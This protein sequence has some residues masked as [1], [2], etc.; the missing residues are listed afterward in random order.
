MTTI[1]GTLANYNNGGPVGIAPGQGMFATDSTRQ[2]LFDARSSFVRMLNIVFARNSITIDRPAAVAA[3]DV[4]TPISEYL[5]WRRPTGTQHVEAIPPTTLWD[6]EVYNIDERN[7][8]LLDATI[9]QSVVDGDIVRVLVNG[10]GN[11]DAPQWSVYDAVCPIGVTDPAV[12]PTIPGQVFSVSKAYDFHVPTFAARDLLLQQATPI[13]LGQQVLVDGNTSTA[14]FWTVWRYVG[15]S[16]PNADASG[17]LLVNYQ[18]YRTADFWSHVDW[19]ATGYSAAEPPVVRYATIAARDAAEL[20]NPTTTFVRVDDDGTGVWVWTT[21]AD[22]VWTVVARQNGTIAFSS[23]FY[24]DPTRPVIGLGPVSD[25]VLAQIPNRD[26]SLELKV[27]FDILQDD[28]LLENSEINEIFFSILHFIHAQQ[29]QVA[30]AFKTSFLT[31]GGYNEVL[32]QAPVQ[33]PDNTTNLLNYLQEVTP[34]RVKTRDFTQ[35]VTPLI[36]N[37][38][39]HATDFD[40]PLYYDQGVGRYRNLNPSN[41]TDL[42]II[43][44][45]APWSDWYG[46]YLNPEFRPPNY[47]ASSWNG[48]RHFNITM[49]FDRVDHM[50]IL[51]DEEFTFG[52]NNTFFMNDLNVDLTLSIVEVYVNGVRLDDNQFGVS[53]NS[54]ILYVTMTNGDIVRVVVRQSLTSG[55]AADRINRFYDPTDSEAAERNLRTLL[56]LNF[57]GNVMDGGML[58]NNTIVDY[59]IIGVAN[60][61][62]TDETINPDVFFHSLADPYMSENHPEELIPTFGGEGILILANDNGIVTQMSLSRPATDTL[63]P[64]QVGDFDAVPLDTISFDVGSAGEETADQYLSNADVISGLITLTK[65]APSTSPNLLGTYRTS[66]TDERGIYV[67]RHDAWEFTNVTTTA[68][69]LNA[70]LTANANTISI[71]LTSANSITLPVVE[72]YVANTSVANTITHPGVIWI[73][74]ERIEFFQYTAGANN[75]VVLGQIRRGT[76]NTQIGVEHRTV[77]SFTADG[78]SK[79]FFIAN[80]PG[81]QC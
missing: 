77:L 2:G 26:G 52:Q 76:H 61:A 3:L 75:T 81:R 40:F 43:K 58:A 66:L 63:A 23:Q 33:P 68:A 4:E 36:E 47:L 21:Y 74:D 34:Y 15:T 14:G 46:T 62:S 29:D 35:I 7:G 27:L 18:T 32:T 64:N 16:D 5:V 31:V 65:V 41:S 57:R 72:Q 48:V 25:S 39:T 70:D 1:S 73:N 78:S 6:Y 59:N 69:T 55:L 13:V 22:G 56:G 67:I 71:T 37:T 19:Y 44:S 28:T 38:V 30:W 60:G 79:A 54:V 51:D 45:T 80:T 24:D 49:R 42:A 12:L 8:L 50:P 10:L 20:P 11:Q 9:A 53:Q 17:F